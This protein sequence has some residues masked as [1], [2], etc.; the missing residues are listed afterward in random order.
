MSK[1]PK[2]AKSKSFSYTPHTTLPTLKKPKLQWDLKGLFYTSDT[3]PQLEKDAIIYE[4]AVQKFVKKYRNKGFTKDVKIL[5]QALQDNEK[6]AARAEGARIMRYLGFRTVLNVND[7]TADKKAQIMSQRFR[8]LSNELLFFKLE[9]GQIPKPEQRNLLADPSLAH[10]RYYLATVFEDAKHHLTESEE[11]ILTLRANTSSGMWADAVEKVTSNR[12]VVF[13]KHTYSVPEALEILDTLSWND[14]HVLWDKL[15]DEM[16]KIGEFAEHELTAI[17]TH[18]KISDEL[19]GFKKPYSGTIL[20]YE[21]DEKA[22]EALVEAISTKGFALSK[23]FYQLKAKLHGVKNIPYANKYDPIGD[24]PQPTFE[25]SVELCRDVFYG[26]KT[27]YGKIFDD[28]L[29][30][31]QIDVYPKKGKRGGAFMSATVGLPTF[32]MLN[33]VANV[34]SLETLAHEMGHAVHAERSKMQSALYEDFSTTTA[35]TASTLFEQLTSQALL[36]ALPEDQQIIFLHDKISRDIAT[37]QRQI[38]FFNFELEMHERIRAEGALTSSELATMMQKHLRSYLG[39]GVDV[40]EKDGYSYVYIPHIRYGFYVYTY[41]YGHLM[42][43]LMI[44][45]YTANPSYV[46]KIDTFLT[47][48]GSDTVENIFAKIG[49]NAKKIDTFLESL[50]TQEEE[51]KLLTKL[52]R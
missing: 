24:L 34:K 29:I 27:E 8:K 7:S 41:T 18:E 40:T 12:T 10:F 26:L 21:N 47:A 23:K 17:V 50:K 2:T 44:Q 14:K 19:R 16:V 52:T 45:K 25:Q 1:K 51:I 42:S 22:V 3:D 35:E 48:G 36:Q 4:R 46:D 43:N 32:V 20:A 38:A 28:M 13:K 9:L 11:R 49:I 15:M 5:L 39:T 6:L 30:G 31:G 33:H 37:I